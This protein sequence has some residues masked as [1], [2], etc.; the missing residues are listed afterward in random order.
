MIPRTDN[1][2]STKPLFASKWLGFAAK[3]LGFYPKWLGY[4]NGYMININI[5]RHILSIFLATLAILATL[6]PRAY[7]ENSR[8]HDICKN[9]CG[10]FSFSTYTLFKVARVARLARRGLQIRVLGL[11]TSKILATSNGHS[12]LIS[13]KMARILEVRT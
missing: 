6:F 4:I 13:N 7:R 5:Y 10:E 3:W 11:A 9:V 12:R 2:R 8:I 1:D